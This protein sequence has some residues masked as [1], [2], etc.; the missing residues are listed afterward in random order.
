MTSCF[1]LRRRF[2]GRSREVS[3]RRRSSSLRVDRHLLYGVLR[4]AGF[5]GMR[6]SASSGAV[7]TAQVLPTT[8]TS[9]ATDSAIE[10]TSTNHD[11]SVTSAERPLEAATQASSDAGFS[12]ASRVSFRPSVSSIGV[13]RPNE[14]EFQALPLDQTM[15]D[16][17]HVVSHAST[18]YQL[19]P[20]RLHAPANHAPP[21]RVVHRGSFDVAPAQSFQA[22]SFTSS[23]PS[24]YHNPPTL[25]PPSHTH[26]FAPS[27]DNVAQWQLQHHEQLCRQQREATHAQVRAN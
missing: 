24:H 20:S 21:A 17:S 11:A 26:T 2:A 22:V 7:P 14:E 18:S 16:P 19:P 10:R 4:V 9:V 5:H 13:G 25:P 3:A 23:L 12:E 27:Y 6:N 15:Q 1:G 8:M